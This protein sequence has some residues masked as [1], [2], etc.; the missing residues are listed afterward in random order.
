[1]LFILTAQSYSF[2][3]YLYNLTHKLAES[4]VSLDFYSA[5]LFTKFLNKARQFLITHG[6]K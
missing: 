3:P 6:I 1:M 5:S 2:L 4:N